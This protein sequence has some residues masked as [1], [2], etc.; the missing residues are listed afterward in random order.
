M[1]RKAK[2]DIPE[3]TREQL[4]KGVRGKYFD[5]FTRGSEQSG[6]QV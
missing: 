5:A 2:A 3:L 6:G 1:K 4:D